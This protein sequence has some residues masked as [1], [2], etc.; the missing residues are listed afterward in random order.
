[1]KYLIIYLLGFLC[2][3]LFMKI[4][5]R[6]KDNNNWIDVKYTIFFALLSWVSCIIGLAI[7][8]VEVIDKYFK[9]NKKPPK[10]M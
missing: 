5:V 2:S 6:K 8:I 10:W 7:L 3:Y 4:F 1:M 9:D